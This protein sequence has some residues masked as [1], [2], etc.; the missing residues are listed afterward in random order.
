MQSDCCNA[1]HVEQRQLLGT[2][3]SSENKEPHDTRVAWRL[4]VAFLARYSYT[5]ERACARVTPLFSS[6]MSRMN[7]FQLAWACKSFSRL[8]W[9]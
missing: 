4:L 5:G 9:H 8:L 3:P 6:A 7:E 1:S 2:M